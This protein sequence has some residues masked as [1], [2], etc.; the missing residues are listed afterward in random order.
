MECGIE[1]IV[2]F[3]CADASGFKLRNVKVSLR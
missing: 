1:Q 2:P 3:T